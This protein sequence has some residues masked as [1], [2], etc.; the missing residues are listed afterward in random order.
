[1]AKALT[2]SVVKTLKPE[3]G[4]TTWREISDSGCR[5][6]RLRVSPSGEKVWAVKVTVG[7]QR[8]RHTIGAYPAVS[9]G[10]ARKR[11]EAYLATARDGAS[12]DELD[13]RQRAETMTV[14]MAHSE[15]I[16]AM[17]SSLR[18][19]TISLKK[20]MFKTHV[21]GALGKRLIRTVR[22]SDVVDVVGG[23]S[24]KGFP[25]QANRVFSEVMALLRWCEQKGYV[26]GV[27]SARKKD[28]RAATGGAKELAR[29]RVLSEG[30]IIAVWN[31]T[32][33]MGD[34]TGDFLRLLLLTGQ[35]RDEVRLMV[36]GEVDMDASLWTIPASRYKTGYSHTVPLPKQAM[37]IL[38]SRWVEGATGYVL[39]G[40][41]E[42][43]PFNG[44]ASA[45]RRLRKE[46]GGKADFTLHDIRRTL[47]TGLARM[48][49]DETTAEMVIG[50][51][52]QGIVK[53]YDQ[54]DRMEERRTALKR[55]AEYVERVATVGSNVFALQATK[56]AG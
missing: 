53:V 17:R 3:R 30:E 7:A 47:R 40:R 37:D 55:W 25:V 45:V 34:L 2:D 10:E 28:V 12:P 23:V 13:A 20:T 27:P 19:S 41:G 6:L 43:K 42:N 26:D 4:A 5:G 24:A 48:G 9:L 36:W 8:V 51:I 52:P 38:R 35:R 44:A 54:H 16:E 15:Y 39:A 32:A 31:L 22:R 11:A 33:N 1:M 14:T 49:I 21:E 46:L 18:A 56:G 50:H 29:R